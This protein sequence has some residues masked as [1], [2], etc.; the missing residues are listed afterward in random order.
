MKGRLFK[1]IKLDVKR[2][3][4]DPNLAGYLIVPF[5][6][7]LFCRFFIP[8]ISVKYPD[9]VAYHPLIMMSGVMQTAII[10]GFITS[11]MILDEKDD[12]ILQVIRVMP[13]T[14]FYF[15]IY[16]LTF[17]TFFSTLGALMMFI[18][19][20]IAYP[21]LWNSVLLSIIYGLTAPFI[22]LIIATYANNKVEGMAYFKFVDLILM[23]PLL[24]FFISGI[25]K[26][27]FAII[28]VYWAHTLYEDSL[29]EVTHFGYFLVG[30]VVNVL[31]L[32]I[33]YFQFRR[34][35]F[36]R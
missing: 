14:S 21:G 36:D 23:L 1:L 16:R 20:G 8:Y 34:R 5:G 6:L 32:T 4:T 10:F 35:V 9:V 29:E 18:L 17:A 13:I 25:G 24:S 26:Y 33:L 12:N 31:V 11:F 28:P 27:A 3:I 19:S 30:V 2:I 7:I 15:I 22:T